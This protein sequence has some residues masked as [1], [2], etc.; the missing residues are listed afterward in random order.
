MKVEVFI[1]H[2]TCLNCRLE[3]RDHS[4]LFEALVVGE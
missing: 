2:W 1:A 4:D 3:S